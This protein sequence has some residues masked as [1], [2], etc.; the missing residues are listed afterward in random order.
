MV[1]TLENESAVLDILAREYGRE[2]ALKL[3]GHYKRVEYVRR[4]VAARIAESS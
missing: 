4:S 2:M 3:I 1:I